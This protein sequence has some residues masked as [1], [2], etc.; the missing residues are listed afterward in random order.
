MF[1]YGRTLPD[2]SEPLRL[3]PVLVIKGSAVDHFVNRPMTDAPVGISAQRPTFLV[4]KLA[5][6][7]D[8]IKSQA[9]SAV[10]YQDRSGHITQAPLAK[11]TCPTVRK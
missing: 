3:W 1:T 11:L 9:V 7:T 4:R 6:T 2:A 5:S 8:L 10:S